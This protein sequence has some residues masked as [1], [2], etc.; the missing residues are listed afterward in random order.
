MA[1]YHAH[2]IHR[3]LNLVETTVQ[4]LHYLL[5]VVQYAPPHLI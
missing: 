5:C 1:S 4:V 2:N 3:S